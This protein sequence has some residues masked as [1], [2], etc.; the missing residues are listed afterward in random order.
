MKQFISFI[1][2]VFIYSSS[3]AQSNDGIEALTCLEFVNGIAENGIMKEN[4]IIKE[5][6]YEYTKHKDNMLDSVLSAV[7]F[8]NVSGTR[9]EKWQ[10]F[11]QQKIIQKYIYQYDESNRIFGLQIR[12]D[13]PNTELA[14]IVVEYD[15]IGRE[16]NMYTYN[17]DTTQL[18]IRHKEY[19]QHGYLTRVYTRIGNDSFYISHRYYYDEENRLQ[20]IDGF[21][22][23]GTLVYGLLYKYDSAKN[24]VKLFF[25]V[26]DQ[27]K[28][29]AEYIYDP[30]HHLI[31][32][33]LLQISQGENFRMDSPDFE[34]DY[35][36]ESYLSNIA[37]V[38]VQ[39]SRYFVYNKNGTLYESYTL[40][41]G[42]KRKLD[43]TRHYYITAEQ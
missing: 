20:K 17:H 31:K 4:K 15:T 36:V 42:N 6:V 41:R 26:G 10:L 2:A 19:D 21:G 35:N 29:L 37:V 3:L 7:I 23:R 27:A 14:N 38:N 40:Q 28:P 18:S 12:S 39:E 24:A 11:D 32:S 30:T 13:D 33:T 5:L 34:N 9:L 16:L 25:R 22:D 8:Y 43:F 1:S